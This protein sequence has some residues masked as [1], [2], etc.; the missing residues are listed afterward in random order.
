MFCRVRP[1]IKED[2]GGAGA[3]EIVTIDP[4]DDGVLYISSKGRVQTFEV[5]RVFADNSTQLEVSGG[6]GG[7]KTKRQKKGRKEK[8]QKIKRQIFQSDKLEI[9]IG[10]KGICQT[11]ISDF[12]TC[13]TAQIDKKKLKLIFF[14]W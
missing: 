8:K 1:V 10:L 13:Q 6:G 5:D 12:C 3:E 9:L 2:G 14:F 4:D 7:E 11:S